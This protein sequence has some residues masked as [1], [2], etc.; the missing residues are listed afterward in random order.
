MKKT[1]KEELIRIHEITYG[2]QLIK[3]GFIDDILQK[4]GGDKSEKTI[5]DPKKADLVSTDV[6]EFFKTIE[7][8]A[9]SGGLKLLS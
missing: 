1:L 2:K 8:A 6:A 3:E 7:D 4:V 5:D 9:N